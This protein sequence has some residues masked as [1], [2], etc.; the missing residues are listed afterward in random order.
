V[1]EPAGSQRDAASAIFNLP[2]YRVIDAVEH[3]DGVRRVHVESTAP[4]G[5]PVCGVLARAGALPAAAAVAEFPGGRAG[6]ADLGQAPL[7]LR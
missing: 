6:G 4:P 1:F 3:A 2:D 5:C 7:V